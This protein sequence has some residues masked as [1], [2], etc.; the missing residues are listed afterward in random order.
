MKVVRFIGTR[1]G[2][3]LLVLFA[4]TLLTFVGVNTLGDPLVNI[5]GPLAKVDCSA[6]EAGEAE[7]FS[8]QGGTSEGDCAIVAER[9]AE[10]NLDD[11][12]FV[13]YGKWVGDAVQG[14]FGSSFSQQRP[15]SDIIKEKLPVTLRMAAFALVLS[16]LISVPW[17]LLAAFRANRA[18]DRGSTV[19]SFGM[20]AVPNFAVGVILLFLF[21]VK[22]QWL[23]SRYEPG[24]TYS[25][26]KSLFLP[27]L[28]LALPLAATYQ[29]LLRTDLIGTLQ[30]DF[31]HMA[32]AKGMPPRHI[33][34]RHALRPS[35]FSMITV[36]GINTGALL[37]GTLVIEQIFS[38]PGIGSEAVKSIV[39]DDFPTVLA[40]VLIIVTAFVV[41]N[42]LV[43]L[44]YTFLDPR[45]R[46]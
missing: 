3:L 38:V 12:V 43:D 39:R 29:R 25:Q 26:F 36:F 18:F 7:D 44:L 40:I 22:L 17:A 11:N 33:M 5:L 16:L 32:R 30:E 31:V 21:A 13:R 1:I 9:R 46:S 45:V 6:V 24:T 14:D 8:S 4:V 28:T 27:S 2:Q 20:L 37:G 15:V 10:F 19:I 23:P 41:M 42:M 34:T 35:M